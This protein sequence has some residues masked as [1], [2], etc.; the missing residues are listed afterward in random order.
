[1]KSFL[2]FILFIIAWFIYYFLISK[3]INWGL[4][5]LINALNLDTVVGV[6]IF[7]FVCCSVIWGVLF[8]PTLLI[9]G[10]F[11]DKA[12]PATVAMILMIL[13]NVWQGYFYLQLSWY[14]WIVLFVHA[15]ATIL[16]LWIIKAT[17]KHHEKEIDEIV[18]TL[19]M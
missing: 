10:Y 8:F 2:K 15:L 7:V 1:M 12:A 6:I 11:L 13:F 9:G 19:K 3:A 16:P 17:N 14:M 4:E 5:L 18:E